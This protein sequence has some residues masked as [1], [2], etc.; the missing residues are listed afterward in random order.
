MTSHENPDIRINNRSASERTTK[1]R[2]PVS[3]EPCRKRK[4]RCS[5][6][7]PPCDT[8]QRRRCVDSCIYPNPQDAA[9]APQTA[10]SDVNGMLLTRISNLENV[11]RQHTQ[12]IGERDLMGGSMLS[13]PTEEASQSYGLSPDSFTGVAQMSYTPASLSPQHVGSLITSTSGNTRYEP[14]MSQWT[15]VLANTGMDLAAPSLE[16]APDSPREVECG[17]PFTLGPV[18][19]TEELIA[20]LPPIQHCDYLK[21]TYF[22][23]FSPV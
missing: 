5:R 15:A 13:P 4:I 18:P 10:S 7:R 19:S 3:C 17:F 6:T 14:R 22:K 1:V 23:V 12:V 2:Q 16:E 20:L 8:C 21:N 9:P 11:L